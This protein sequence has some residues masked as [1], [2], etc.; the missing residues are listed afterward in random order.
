[1]IYQKG[2]Q[3]NFKQKL[4]YMG[5]GCLFTILGYIVA[6]LVTNATAQS[7]PTVFDEIV[8]KGITVRGG[9]ITVEGKGG[10]HSTTVWYDGLTI[11]DRDP[12]STH[13]VTPLQRWVTL[14][15]RELLFTE[16]Y[17]D[18]ENQNPHSETFIASRVQINQSGLTLRD[19]SDAH[20]IFLG[21]RN[22]LSSLKFDDN[23][24]LS[25]FNSIGS[26][27]ISLRNDERDRSTL[28]VDG[29]VGVGDPKN[30]DQLG[31]LR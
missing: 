31:N 24:Y 27:K 28:I 23:L 18:E 20:P 2:E 22:G 15:S 8:C 5:F 25:V 21:Y 9:Q 4:A 1:M 7:E 17:P 26:P 3:M 30:Q 14:G 6:N 13:G 16:Y 12:F 19:E 29:F 11:R 10:G